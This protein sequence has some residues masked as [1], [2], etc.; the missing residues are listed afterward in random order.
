MN[1]TRAHGVAAV[2]G[3]VAIVALTLAMR[4]VDSPPLWFELSPFAVLGLMFWIK[5]LGE[6]RDERQSKTG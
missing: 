2:V 5:S 1:Q 3:L 4:A 6:P